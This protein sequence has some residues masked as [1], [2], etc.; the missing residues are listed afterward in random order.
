[1]SLEDRE[2]EARLRDWKL[3]DAGL[4]DEGQPTETA[5][6]DYNQKMVALFTAMDRRE[7]RYILGLRRPIAIHKVLAS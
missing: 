1:M 2:F 6:I 7:I 4:L 5:T 3:V